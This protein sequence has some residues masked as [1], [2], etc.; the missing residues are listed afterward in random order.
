MNRAG[1]S[2]LCMVGVFPPPVHGMAMVNAEMRDLL[3][4][5]GA[6]PLVL[7]LAPT[8]LRRNWFNRL[9]RIGKV[10][11]AFTRYLREIFGGRG[12][13]LYVGLSGGWGQ[14][15]EALFV[16]SA[17]LRRARIFLHHHSFAYLERRKLPARLL[18]RL[19]GAS[20]THVVI[21]QTQEQKLRQSYPI[22][23]RTRVVSN[24]A[25][26]DR[27]V[28][29]KHRTRTCVQKIGFLGNISREKGIMEVL[30]IAE[31]LEGQGAGFEVYIAGPFE[32]ATVENAVQEAAARLHTVKYVGPRYGSDKE[33]FWDLIDILLFPS[34][35]SNET[36]PL[37]VHEAMAH[38]IPVIAWAR[39]CLSDMVASDSGLLVQ[40]DQDFVAVAL[41]CLL[42][43]Q[44]DPAVFAEM[45]NAAARDFSRQHEKSRDSLVALLNELTPPSSVWPD[46]AESPMNSH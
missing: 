22:A 40:R 31:R 34:T 25:I 3:S 13:T 4:G 19:A 30:A 28:E 38:G 46:L 32:N 39:G 45:S 44:R 7:D 41:E 1:E 11:K 37:V 15:Y 6:E 8:S 14:M 21:C 43:W 33:S 16:A 10:A 36:A 12:S 26:M 9:A 24:A 2:G 42:K 20:A 29:A 27:A 18:V 35:Y 23:S 17:R 5:C